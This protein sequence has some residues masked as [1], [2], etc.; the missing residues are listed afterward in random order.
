MFSNLTPQ[1]KVQL[2]IGPALIVGVVLAYFLSEYF[3]VVPVLIG[4]GL[5]RAGATGTCPMEKLFTKKD[6]R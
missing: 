3:L 1:R 4:F 2:T 6:S 5:T